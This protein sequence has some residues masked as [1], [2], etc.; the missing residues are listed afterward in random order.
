MEMGQA[1]S[2]SLP[3]HQRMLR[4]DWEE[5]PANSAAIAPELCAALR[6]KEGG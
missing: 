3:S 4:R 1:E 5:T 6:G 2:A